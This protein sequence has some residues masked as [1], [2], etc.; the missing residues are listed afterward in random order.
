MGQNGTQLGV[1]LEA[2]VTDFARR[3]IL[4]AIRSR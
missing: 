3:G 2:I 4:E 1:A